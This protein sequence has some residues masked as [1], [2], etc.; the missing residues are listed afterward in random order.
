MALAIGHIFPV[1]SFYFACYWT[2]LTLIYYDVC[3]V[4]N[5]TILVRVLAIRKQTTAARILNLLQ[6][7]Q[8]KTVL[9]LVEWV[10]LTC[11]KGFCYILPLLTVL[12]SLLH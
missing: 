4:E 5:I 2:V 9:L 1:A 10:P 6:K 3:N 8:D 12:L 11:L 7:R